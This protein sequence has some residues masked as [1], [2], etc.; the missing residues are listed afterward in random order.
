[1]ATTN[2]RVVLTLEEKL[3][4]AIQALFILHARQI[5]MSNKEM[6]ELLGG[7]QTDI[8]AAAKVV[9]KALKRHGKSTA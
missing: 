7:D 6:R 3:Y 8:D 9:N 1:M 4:R 5:D 2:K